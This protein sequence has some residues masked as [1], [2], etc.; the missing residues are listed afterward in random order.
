MLGIVSLLDDR[1]TEL[2]EKLWVEMVQPF[3]VGQST[4]ARLILL[5]PK[6]L[7]C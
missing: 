3:G 6:L 4:Y 2:V 5:T 7:N 1:H